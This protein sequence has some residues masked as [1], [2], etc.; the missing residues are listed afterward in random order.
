MPG[1]SC[2]Y[3]SGAAFALQMGVA[4][5][6]CLIKLLLQAVPGLPAFLY[7]NARRGGME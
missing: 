7:G 5:G 2:V 4:C 1:E 3:V 6:L